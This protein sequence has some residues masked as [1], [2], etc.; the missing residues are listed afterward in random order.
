MESEEILGASV[1]EK[2]RIFG[3]MTGVLGLAAVLGAAALSSA[4]AQEPAPEKKDENLCVLDDGFV[5]DWVVLVGVPLSLNPKTVETTEDFIYGE[6][7]LKPREGYTF[8][9]EKMPAMKV[10]RWRTHHAANRMVNFQELGGQ[11]QMMNYAVAYLVT[12]KAA[13]VRVELAAA[14][15][16]CLVRLN[17]K[18]LAGPESDLVEGQNVLLV[19]LADQKG[20][21]K[22]SLRVLSRDGKVLPD[23]R[24]TLVP[25]KEEEERRLRSVLEPDPA[26]I[27]FPKQTKRVSYLPDAL[28]PQ[29]KQMSAK[30]IT[31]IIESQQA[32]GAWSDTQYPDSVGVTALCCLAL[33]AEG[34]LPRQGPHGKSL[35]KGIEF[36]L[37]SFKDEGVC[38]STKVEGYGVM[39]GHALAIL[40]LLEANGNMPWR[41]EVEDRISKGLQTILRYQRLDG[42]WR[43]ELTK[44]GASDISVTTTVLWALGQ[45]RRY[46][47]TV[48]RESV[49]RAVR[50]VEQC[51]LPDGRFRYRLVGKAKIQPHSG[52]GVAALYGVGRIDHPLLPAARDLIAREYQRYTVDD[53]SDRSYIMF[54][55]FFAGLTMYSSGYDLWTPWYTKM[56]EIIAHLQQKDGEVYDQYR[57][58]TYP[59]ALAAIILQAPYGYLSI[60]VQ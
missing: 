32:N 45:A 8:R 37:G 1:T 38:A 55:S 26:F 2:K 11:P 18:A 54:G 58:K 50:F 30:A 42:G 57:N 49:D 4:F 15:R 6:S 35:D 33:M 27:L 22:F 40:A 14:P 17:G 3:V 36:L 41:P 46:G 12:A 56:V 51:G 24:I 9:N 16:L 48:P 31:F 29:V 34:N 60:F 53:L 10:L 5:R 23:L 20:D 21:G 44:T 59:T 47:Y 19:R 52:V 28:T 13:P 43:Y 7:E 39:Y 25:G